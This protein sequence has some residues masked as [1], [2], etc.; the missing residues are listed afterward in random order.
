MRLG[1]GTAQ[2]GFQYGVTNTTG[3]LGKDEALQILDAA[4]SKG[5]MDID[6]SPS[7]EQAENTIGKFHLKDKVRVITKTIKHNASVITPEIIQRV[8]NGVDTSLK[9]LGLERCYALLIH[10]IADLSKPG[11]NSLL[12]ALMELK[13]SGKVQKLGVSAYYVNEIEL[14]SELMELDIVQVPLSVANQ[15]FLKKDTLKQLKSTGV[16]IHARS[17]FLQGTLLAGQNQL[18]K[19]LYYLSETA[20]QVKSIASKLAITPTQLCLEFIQQTKLVDVAIVGVNCT[21][22]LSDFEQFSPVS[23]TKVDWDSFKISDTRLTNPSYW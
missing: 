23:S 19:K 16:E 5:I 11:F 18:P 17:V 12:S 6:T 4:F 1:I 3:Q 7:Y 13:L 21:D 15:D 10:D 2:F 22:H 8:I 9:A 20:R 14:A